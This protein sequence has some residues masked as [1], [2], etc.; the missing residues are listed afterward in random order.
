METRL[1]S[2][3][4]SIIWRITGI[5]ILAIITYAFT[6]SWIQ[7]G[8]ITVLH[9]SIFLIVFYLHERIWLRFPIGNLMYQSLAKMLTYE[10]LCGN[11]VLGTITY[12]VTGNFKQMTAVTLTYI[13]I[14]H[15]CYIAN[16]FVWKRCLHPSV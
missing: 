10:T 6:K 4:K 11:L 7:T 9:H 12:A 5:I 15:I 13:G 1:R 16:E 2:G 14:K 8:L 3:V